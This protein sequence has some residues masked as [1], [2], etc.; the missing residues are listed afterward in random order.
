MLPNEEA[1]PEMD[2][3][4]RDYFQAELP[5]PWPAFKAPAVAQLKTPASF[6]SRTGGRLA[7]AGT[8]A[9]LVFGYLALG[10]FFPRT[11]A[12]TGVDP[13]APDAARGFDKPK[14]PITT[15]NQ[16]ETLQ[17]PQINDIPE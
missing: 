10:T 1:R 12:P 5:H 16:V 15:L 3:L 8:V 7:L 14:K 6:W 9:V 2:D 13:A 4:L 11:K 17:R